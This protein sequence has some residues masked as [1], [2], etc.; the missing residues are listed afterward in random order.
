MTI[1]DAQDYSTGGL[2]WGGVAPPP[3]SQYHAEIV[4][5]GRIAYRKG[6]ELAQGIPNARFIT[7]ESNNHLILEHDPEFPRF[8]TSIRSFLNEG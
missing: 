5:D 2:G 8:M 1:E 7:L 6:L 3:R 4:N